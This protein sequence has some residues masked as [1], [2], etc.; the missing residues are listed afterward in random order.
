MEGDKPTGTECCTVSA[1]PLRSAR[2]PEGGDEL[3]EVRVPQAAALR[4]P[5]PRRGAM[6]RKGSG[7]MGRGGEGRGPSLRGWG[8]DGPGQA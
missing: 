1:P 2:T 5:Q 6:G 4:A 7:Y 3:P 8:R